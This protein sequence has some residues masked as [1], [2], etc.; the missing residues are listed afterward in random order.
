MFPIATPEQLEAIGGFAGKLAGY[1][2][3]F[4][5][6]IS[7]KE[8]VLHLRQIFETASIENGF[9]GAFVSHFGNKQWV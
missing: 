5:G 4:K 6:P 3:D 8:S 7:P 9:A 2:P 1:A